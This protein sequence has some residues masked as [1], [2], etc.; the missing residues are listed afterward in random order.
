MIEFWID[1]AR[2][3]IVVALV[4]DVSGPDYTSWVLE[5]LTA[6]PVVA[7]YDFIYDL[8]AYHGRISH[9]DIAALAPRYAALVG[10]R[11]RGATTVLVTPDEGFR[12]WAELMAIQ[13][14]NR[15]WHVL[16]GMAEAEAMLAQRDQ[17]DIRPG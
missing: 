5:R 6:E 14:P 13:F 1:H 10:D 17:G 2:H 15:R 4:G 8:H 3:R 7:G 11:D 16:P 9:D 12:F